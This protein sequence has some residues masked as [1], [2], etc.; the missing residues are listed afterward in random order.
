[1]NT[2][3]N[4]SFN[5]EIGI[6]G[7]TRHVSRLIDNGGMHG[8]IITIEGKMSALIVIGGKAADISTLQGMDSTKVKGFVHFLFHPMR[9]GHLILH[10]SSVSRNWFS[11]ET[12][13]VLRT[14]HHALAE[15]A[16]E[17]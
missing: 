1:M 3:S 10:T 16:K 17:R 11:R 9:F 5:H 14:F 6:H 13:F 8:L 15:K 4:L 2:V 7:I 12:R